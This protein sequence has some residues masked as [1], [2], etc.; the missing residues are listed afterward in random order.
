VTEQRFLSGQIT[1][2]PHNGTLSISFPGQAEIWTPMRG[3]TASADYRVNGTRQHVTLEDPTTA[4]GAGEN[5]VTF[6]H[7]DQ[8]VSLDWSWTLAGDTL[9]CWLEISNRSQVA[10]AIDR[11]YVLCLTGPASLDLP[12]P[13]ANWRVYQNGWQSWTPAGVRRVGNGPFPRPPDD[14]Y[15]RKNLPHEAE[16]QPGGLSS[17]WVTVIAAAPEHSEGSSSAPAS[18]SESI[19]LLFGFVTGADQLAE[20]ILDADDR[21]RSL[22]ATCHADGVFLEPG[23]A[24][25]SERLRVAT[26]L[27]GLASLE[28]WAGRMGELMRARIPERTPAGWCT[29]YCHLGFNTAQDVYANLGAMRRQRLPLTLVMIDDGY[30]TAIGDWL[31]P[32]PERFTDMAAAAATIRREGRMPGIWTAPFGLA[33]GSG[34]YANHP[35]WV[36]K[37]ETGEPVLGWNHLGHPVYA[38]D[39]THPEVVD[40]LYTTFQSIRHEWG[41]DAFKLDFLFAAALP[42]RRHDP[43]ITRAQALRRALALIRDAVGHDAFLLGCGAPLAPA[44]GLVDGMRIGPDIHTTWEPRFQG[45]L[46]A[47]GAANAL[48][49]NIARAFTHRRLWAADPDCLPLR[50][51]GESSQLT[52][53]EAHTL[54]TVISLTGSMF[55]DG[56]QLGKLPPS[57]LAMLRQML[58]PTDRVAYPLDLFK[59]DVPQVLV[60]P[61]ERPWGRWWLVG[62]V[63]WDDHTQGFNVEPEALSLP[64]GRYHVYDQ[65]RAVYLG[66]TEGA[67]VLPHQKPHETL[68]LLF[69]PVAEQPDWLTST[70]HLMGGSVEVVDVVRQRLGER[71]LK[72]IVHVEQAGQNFGRLVFTMPAGWVVLD[73]QVKGRRR[74][75]N[76][77]NREAGLVDMGFTLH[78]RAWVLVDFARL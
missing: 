46:S 77:R 16:S 25:R 20:I 35:D 51:R 21:F 72:L 24:L 7:H 69:K 34:T 12:G 40:W 73:A 61:V 42:G 9:E 5:L 23:E 44:V 50:P 57:R 22:S 52:L 75:V 71:R 54:A 14:D 38:I 49:N 29:R 65:W 6:S 41:Y 26:S 66:Q 55:L 43:Q 53:Y 74:S 18:Q 47:P 60:L 31:T 64:A 78:D 36:L 48:R 70:F 17:E 68:L 11:L 13:V 37:N 3:A 28:A 59:R 56:D 33:V 19:C 76:I 58:P 45:D 63:N 62:L 10:V 27:D 2:H 1:F 4:F 67:I 39:T 32:N 8:H 30:Q 15:R